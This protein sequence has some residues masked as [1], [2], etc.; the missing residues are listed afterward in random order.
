MEDRRD[1]VDPLVALCRDAGVALSAIEF[2]DDA[3]PAEGGTFPIDRDA[4]RRAALSRRLVPA[5]AAL[6]VVLTFA[7]VGAIYL[8]GETNAAQLADRVDAA[9]GRAAVVER[10][11]RKLDAANRQAVFLA[12]QKAN[13]AAIAV[14]AKV[15]R[16]L[17]DD[18]W[19]YQFELNGDEVRMHGFSSS[20]ASL[21]AV[22]DNSPDFHDAEMRSPLMQGPTGATQRFDMAV[23]VR[24][25][26]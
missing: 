15:A 7:L 25:P 1:A 20:A 6:I 9:R 17:P 5:L 18:A 10:L 21:I 8:R 23:K 2:A 4:A 22:F 13:P 3:T 12:Q 26:R 19:L 14:L 24:Q 16:L 11:Q